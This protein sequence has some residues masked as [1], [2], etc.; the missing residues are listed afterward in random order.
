MGKYFD[1]FPKVRYSLNEDRSNPVVVTD[2]TFPVRILDKFTSDRK[3]Y[4]KHIVKDGQKPE[5]VAYLVYGDPQLHAIILQFNS[6]VNP[7]F[8]WPLSSRNL[9]LFIENKYGSIA[10]AYTNTAAYYKVVKRYSSAST[11]GE[12]DV[13]KI[14]V[15]EA[16]YANI[17]LDLVGTEYA[18]ANSSGDEVVRVVVEREEISAYDWELE[19]NEAKREIVLIQK[20]YIE[21]IRAEINALASGDNKKR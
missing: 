10:N 12:P 8:D 4:Y 15:N 5:D 13:Q 21:K 17:E 18:L 14:K 16:E 9:E 6:M 19:Q 11:D 1:K 3:Y 7:R 2:V 20:P